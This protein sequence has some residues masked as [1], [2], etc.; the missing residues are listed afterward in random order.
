MTKRFWQ[1]WGIA[2]RWGWLLVLS[3]LIPTMVA[4]A[5]VS[6]QPNFY[7]AKAT[8]MVGS[9]LQTPDPDPWQLAIA[10]S[11]ANAYAR[12][13]REGPV[14]QA[15]IDR[16]GLDRSPSQLASQITTQVNSEAQL[17]E[18]QVVDQDPRLAAAVA[19]AIAQELVRRSPVSQ[20]EEQERREFIRA[21]LD[22]LEARIERLKEEITGLQGTLPELTSAA[23]L[24]EARRRLEEL[25]TLR[26]NYQS[27]YASL[28]DSLRTEAP[29][30]LSIFES[31]AEPAT[32][33]P[34]RT[35]ITVGVAAI[36]GL[37]LAVA[38]VLVVERLDDTVRWETVEEGVFLDRPV[39]GALP[40]VKVGRE[41]L[42]STLPLRPADMEALRH[43]RTA[44][45]VE[46]EERW[47]AVV[48]IAGADVGVGRTFV[49][50]GLGRA[51]AEAGLRTLL[52]DGDLRSPTL[53]EWFDLPNLEGLAELLR[54]ER[55]LS[56]AWDLIERNPT[57]VDRLH[58][59]PAGRPVS[60]PTVLFVGDRWGALLKEL[61]KGTDVVLVDSAAGF[62]SPEILLIA[63]R[64]DGVLMA[65]GHRRTRTISLLQ[66]LRSLG[67]HIP[68]VPTWLMFNRVPRRQLHLHPMPRWTA[69]RVPLAERPT[70]TVGEAAMVLGVRPAV[71]R[72][73]CRT[74]R[75]QAEYV[76]WRWVVRRE[77]LERLLPPPEVEK[78]PQE[79]PA[80]LN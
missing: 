16:L 24:E 18:I 60:D 38:G 17:L 40:R 14:T 3:V 25:E 63:Q 28:L 77:D 29:N 27:T 30:A 39:L 6:R 20:E 32:P 71:V 59:L 70:L 78:S 11:L 48:L 80:F 41:R 66:M 55:K 79:E 47:P 76:R 23:E 58:L 74:G 12:L 33:L 4:G 50:A 34:R 8:L 64:C 42:L 19:N 68:G 56:T 37:A 72:R 65:C 62:A 26:I 31:A 57:G 49:A 45:V 54:G 51:L 22:D 61:R 75:L 67:E 2:R 1:Y 52:V 5:L 21:Q 43:L 46:L 15:V 44:L 13:A 7:R 9:G 53:H 69:E 73:W 10:N 35:G 36:A